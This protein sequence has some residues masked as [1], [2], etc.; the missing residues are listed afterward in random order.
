MIKL[1]VPHI[2]QTK[3]AC[4]PAA[5]LQVLQ[6]YGYQK[7]LPGLISGLQISPEEFNCSGVAEGTLGLY[8]LKQGFPTTIITYDTKRFDPTWNFQDKEELKKKLNAWLTF[9]KT[10]SDEDKREGYSD[11]YKVVS[12]QHFLEFI[13]E[14]DAVISFQPISPGLIER[15]LL[16]NI[17]PIILVNTCLFYSSKRRY[18]KNKDDIRG[19]AYGHFVVISGFDEKHYWITDPSD[20]FKSAGVYQIEKNKL[21]N[22][23]LQYGPVMLIVH[24]KKD[25]P[26]TQKEV[27]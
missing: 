13:E 15:F 25:I 2:K 21:F 16:K 12:T 14:K 20:D 19:K 3:K 7:N 18:Q 1:A 10:A 23:F 8:A 5:L 26:K 11:Y 22:C 9:L 27:Y 6:F 4:G 17:P 24:P